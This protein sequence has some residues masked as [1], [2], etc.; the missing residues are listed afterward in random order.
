MAR[1]L[2]DTEIQVRV[3]PTRVRWPESSTA[4]VWSKLHYAV[5]ALHALARAVD[6]D[7]AAAEGNRCLSPDDI[8]QQ[9]AAFGNQAL[10]QLE[11]FKTF[12]IAEK[13]VT[14]NIDLL[15]RLTHRDPEQVEAHQ[16]LT[17]ALVDLREGVAATKRAVIE[18]CQMRAM[19]QLNVRFWG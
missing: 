8:A 11:S 3:V 5:D 12:Q 19:P 13:V 4:G 7:C 6:E 18:R 15:E 10:T 17:K 2:T 16:K 14:E 1:R 9:R